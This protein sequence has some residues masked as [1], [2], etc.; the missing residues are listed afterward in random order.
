MKRFKLIRREI[1]NYLYLR[2]TLSKEIKNATADS[3]W[4]KFKLRMNWYGRVYTVVS[5]REQDMGEEEL[6]QNWKAME[7]MRPIN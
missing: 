2:K 4:N 3:S 7:M 1:A 6:V 5:L